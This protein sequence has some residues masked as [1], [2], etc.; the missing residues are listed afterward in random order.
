LD[1]LIYDKEMLSKI[2]GISNTKK[3]L[4]IGK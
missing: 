4:W 3:P 1:Q 2:L